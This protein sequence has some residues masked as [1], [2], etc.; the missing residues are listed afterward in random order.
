MRLQKGPFFFL[1]SCIS[2]L[3]L[4]GCNHLIIQ[5]PAGYFNVAVIVDTMTD[6]VSREQA[7]AVIAIAHE[8][9]LDLT[10]FGFKLVGFVEVENGGSI[11]SMV[12]NYFVSQQGALPNGIIVFSV[13]DD[14]RAKIN[15]AYARQIP[16][17]V[18][19]RN[20][21][22]SPYL[23]DQY[24]YV[25]VLQFYHR[26]AACGYAE[27]DTI[28]SQVSSHGECRGID[29]VACVEWNGMQVCESALEIL[30]GHTPIDLAAGPVIHEFLH[31]FSDRG[32]D[33]HYGSEACNSLMGWQLDHFDLEESEYYN[34][35]CPNLYDIFADS[36]NP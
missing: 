1:L 22:V 19:K 32:P 10:G 11:D 29:G 26:Y 4:A 9:F 24:M 2:I 17:P 28:Q 23:G 8:K 36:Y 25:G 3:V 16:L 18:G 13:G 20:A 34:A 14:N 15:R 21:F 12:G 33:D 5:K 27:T 30:D 35:M 6:P 7:E 31:G